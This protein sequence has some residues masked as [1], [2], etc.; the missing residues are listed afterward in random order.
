TSQDDQLG[1]ANYHTVLT[2]EAWDQLWQ[3]MQN[4]SNSAS[5]KTRVNEVVLSGYIILFIA[6][7]LTSYP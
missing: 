3:R 7:V 4:V 1:T 2:Q 6:S 5:C